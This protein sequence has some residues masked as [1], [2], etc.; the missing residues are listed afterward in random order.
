MIV[1]PVPLG[2][3]GMEVHKDITRRALD[4]LPA[5]LKPFFDVQREFIVEHS[6]DPDLWRI[7]NL[8]GDRGDEEPNHFIDIDGLDEP[9]P[10]TNVPREWDA[11]VKRYGLERANTIGRL[12]WR[13]EE[14]FGTLVT[15]LRE[16]GK[17]SPAYAASNARYL[18]AVLAHY[19]EDAHQPFHAVLNYNGQLTGQ[20][21]I[22]ARFETDLIVRN[23]STIQWAPVDDSSVHERARLRVRDGDRERSAD[24]RRARRRP[25]G[26]G[27]PRV[28]RRRL[29][30]GVLHRRPRHARAAAQRLGQR[31]RERDRERVDRGGPARAAR[32]T[33]RPRRRGFDAEPGSRRWMSISFPSAVSATSCTSK[34][35]TTPPTSWRTDGAGSS[36]WRRK[37]DRFREMLAEA[38][39]DRL[40]RERGIDSGRT[41]IGRWIMSKIAEVVAEQRLLWHL[42]A[43]KPPAG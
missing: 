11:Y 13:I 30:R 2:A 34:S 33:R 19:I 16:A 21:G 23:R 8:R 5:E 9:R 38:E 14:I 43:R 29:L 41:G 31:R 17:G 3:W 28:L 35:T 37:M 7:V 25:Q 36:W 32:S 4:A 27:R 40:L 20:Q 12:P 26:H 6:A 18:A 1:A 24:G 15:R 22:H 39:R 42:R 10:F